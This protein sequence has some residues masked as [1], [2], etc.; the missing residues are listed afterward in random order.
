MDRIRTVTL[1]RYDLPAAPFRPWADAEGQWITHSPVVPEAVQ[2]VGD[3][4][5]LH[6]TAQIELRVTPSLWPLYDLAQSGPWMFSIIRMRN[7]APRP[8]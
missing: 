7:A 2:P 5:A 4:L 1:Y 3:L 6:A 8:T